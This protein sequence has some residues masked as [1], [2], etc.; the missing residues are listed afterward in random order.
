[1]ARLSVSFDAVGWKTA[2]VC[3]LLIDVDKIA[4][5]VGGGGGVGVVNIELRADCSTLLAALLE[6]IG[7]VL[8][9]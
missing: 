5:V 2:F 3:C 1:V 8:D 4:V 7:D 6:S 9:E